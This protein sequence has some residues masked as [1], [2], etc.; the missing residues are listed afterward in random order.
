MKGSRRLLQIIASV[1]G[2]I[3]IGIILALTAFAW[4]AVA[5]GKL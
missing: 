4:Y 5:G 2:F 1:A 3:L